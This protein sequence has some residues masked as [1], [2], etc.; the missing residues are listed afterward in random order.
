MPLASKKAGSDLSFSRASDFIFYVEGQ[1]HIGTKKGLFNVHIGADRSENFECADSNCTG[2]N[3]A[4]I[5]ST[6]AMGTSNL[7]NE[8]SGE[9][10]SFGIIAYKSTN[11]TTNIQTTEAY[12]GSVAYPDGEV[13]GI[14]Y[15]VYD[16]T[17]YSSMRVKRVTSNTGYYLE[18]DYEDL[19]GGDWLHVKTAAIYASANPGTPLARLDY[20]LDGNQVTDALGRTWQ[21]SLGC[22]QY[23]FTSPW[24][25]SDSIVLP[26]EGSGSWWQVCRQHAGPVRAFVAES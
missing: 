16:S 18:L 12:A 20:S 22:G 23:A 24:K 19:P 11:P 1:R 3:S 7:T 10:Y 5:F 9:R 14:T 13:L 8:K 26:G 6:T 25:T 15:Q 4:S 17:Q 2:D 21:C